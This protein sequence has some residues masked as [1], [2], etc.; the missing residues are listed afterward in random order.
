MGTGSGERFAVAR[1]FAEAA[2]FGIE[3]CVTGQKNS[4][5]WDQRVR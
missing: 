2:A 1:S 3:I 5:R 4:I